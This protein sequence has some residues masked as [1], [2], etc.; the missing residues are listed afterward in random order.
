MERK[1]S[2]FASIDA[3]IATFPKE[4]Q[5]LLQA[6][7]AAIHAAA[8]EAEEK[9]SYNMPAFAQH[10]NLVYFAA[11]KEH[12]GLYPTSS[13]IAA[14]KDELARYESSTGAV[15][16]PKREPLPLDLITR[17]VRYRVQ[18]NLAKASAKARPRH[19]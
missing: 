11:L 18:E 17:I 5:E 12:I 10:G 6:V 19:A 14:F 15:R 2:G 9:I 3:Y 13:G 7:R 8:P 4:T 16:F 1:Q